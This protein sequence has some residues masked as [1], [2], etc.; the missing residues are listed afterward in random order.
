MPSNYRIKKI[1]A[2]WKGWIDILISLKKRCSPPEDITSATFFKIIDVIAELGGPPIMRNSTLIIV[3]NLEFEVSKLKYKQAREFDS[4][5]F[6][7]KTLELGPLIM[8]I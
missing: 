1:Q 8:Q 4:L 3:D 6:L 7:K 2:G 5:S